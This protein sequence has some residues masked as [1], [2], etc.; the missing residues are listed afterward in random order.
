MLLL[1]ALTFSHGALAQGVPSAPS[2]GGSHA[3]P[4]TPSSAPAAPPSSSA[5]STPSTASS[6]TTS[7]PSTAS[8]STT[9]VPSTAS[10]DTHTAAS[11]EDLQAEEHPLADSPDRPRNR[12]NRFHTIS[13]AGFGFLTVPS[14]HL[15]IIGTGS[16]TTTDASILAVV[17]AL[18]QWGGPFVL[19]AE[20][21]IGVRP[22]STNITTMTSLG[23]IQRTYSRG[24]FFLAGDFRYYITQ[25][26]T[27]SWWVGGQGGAIIISDS[28]ASSATRTA[29]LGPLAETL[30]TEG[31]LLG[32]GS[33][34][35]YSVSRPLS[36]GLWTAQT[37]WLLPRQ[38][39]C[40]ETNECTTAKGNLFS[41]QFGLSLIYR[42]WL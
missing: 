24:Y 34:L 7:V 10:S 30:H 14:A 6:S 38:Q 16:C 42:I 35:E 8:S 3:P 28:Y 26:D 25:R 13:E 17:R 31:V 2:S 11:E 27:L 41:L 19:G 18:V 15:C 39:T 37:L 36:F 23:D 33:G 40:T 9:S 4:S 5:P 21:G 12:L 22:G 32:V 29:L 1:A 20:A